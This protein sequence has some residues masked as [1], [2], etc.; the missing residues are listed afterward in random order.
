MELLIAHFVGATLTFVTMMLLNYLNENPLTLRDW[1][2]ALIITCFWPSALF[3]LCVIVM[4]D[5]FKTM[6]QN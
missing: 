6:R 5:R 4:T 2:T 1:G 3:S